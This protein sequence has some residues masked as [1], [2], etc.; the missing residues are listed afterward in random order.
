MI[1]LKRR[2]K[3]LEKYWP[4]WLAGE[5]KFWVSEQLKRS[6]SALFQ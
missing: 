1:F 4:R 5:G 2:H 6:N 3:I